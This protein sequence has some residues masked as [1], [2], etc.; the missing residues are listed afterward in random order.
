MVTSTIFDWAN[1][2]PTR[3]YFRWIDPR[4]IF[5]PHWRAFFSSVAVHHNKNLFVISFLEDVPKVQECRKCR[6]GFIRRTKMIPFDIV[7]GHKERWMYSDPKEKTTKF[8]CVR[9]SCIM[10]RSPYFNA[11]FLEI[12]SQTWFTTFWR[13]SLDTN[14]KSKINYRECKISR[15]RVMM[16]FRLYMGKRHLNTVCTRAWQQMTVTVTYIVQ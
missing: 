11:S 15:K 6:T 1:N 2:A 10:E 13:N 12:P 3:V 16:R 5:P 7:L 14:N 4:C 9:K 8:C